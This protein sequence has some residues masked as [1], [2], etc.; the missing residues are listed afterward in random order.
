MQKPT[1]RK[2]VEIKPNVEAHLDKSRVHKRE[3]YND[4]LERLLGLEQQ[5][6]KEASK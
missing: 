2:Y 6:Q 1:K 3:S 4:I 5:E